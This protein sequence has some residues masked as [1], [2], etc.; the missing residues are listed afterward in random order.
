MLYKSTIV[1]DIDTVRVTRCPCRSLC[2]W[3]ISWRWLT[4]TRATTSSCSC[5]VEPPSCLEC[6]PLK[7]CAPRASGPT[8]PSRSAILTTSYRFRVSLSS[9][10][11]VENIHIS[12]DVLWRV[13]QILTEPVSRIRLYCTCICELTE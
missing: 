1:I 7:P 3:R 10:L 11:A 13:F 8:T 12:T 4:W 5:S 6:A 9:A 2:L